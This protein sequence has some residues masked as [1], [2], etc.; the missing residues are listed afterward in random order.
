MFV[1]EYRLPQTQY[2]DYMLRF[3]SKDGEF[4]VFPA[5]VWW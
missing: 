5:E 1:S 4:D 2:G 3:H